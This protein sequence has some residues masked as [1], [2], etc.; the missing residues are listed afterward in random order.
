MNLDQLATAQRVLPDA[1]AKTLLNHAFSITLE[2]TTVSYMARFDSQLN[3]ELI[4]WLDDEE[5][6][7][8]TNTERWIETGKNV[9]GFVYYHAASEGINIRI[10]L[11]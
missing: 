4:R 10:I 1:L 9:T 3:L 5:Q 2:S 8:A 11:T 6:L 7:Q